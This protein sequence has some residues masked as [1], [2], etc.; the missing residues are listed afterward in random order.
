M[1][2]SVIFILMNLLCIFSLSSQNN[3]PDKLFWSNTRKFVV[4]DFGIQTKDDSLGNSSAVFEIEYG[5]KGFNFLRKNFNQKIS[6]YML[7]PSSQIRVDENVDQ[8]LSYQQ[9]M[10][11]I[12]EL[13]VRK[14]R[15][16]V[17]DNRRKL[18]FTTGIVDDLKEEIIDKEM[19]ECQALYTNETN[20]GANKEKQKEWEEKI[21]QELSDLY[22]YA[23]DY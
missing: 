14:L 20:S 22:K 1:Q 8:Y 19:R 13:Y 11:D 23:Y 5:V 16:A 10:F 17:S 21:T 3:D 18:M 4:S 15:K 6:H 7:K 9:V 2:K 12:E